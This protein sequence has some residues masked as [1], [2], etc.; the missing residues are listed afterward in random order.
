MGEKELL[1]S[2]I[3]NRNSQ[4]HMVAFNLIDTYFVIEF[5]N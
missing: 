4:M 2:Y 3:Y 1:K 5:T